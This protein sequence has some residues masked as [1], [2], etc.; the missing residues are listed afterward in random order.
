[1]RFLKTFLILPLCLLSACAMKNHSFV[2]NEPLQVEKEIMSFDMP[3][4]KVSR[5]FLTDLADDVTHRATGD[6]TVTVRYF[7]KKPLKA[8]QQIA[9]KQGAHV[10]SYLQQQGVRQRILVLS[11]PD[12]EEDTINTINISYPALKAKGPSHCA[13]ITH[14]DA[15]RFDHGYDGGYFYGCTGDRY[16]SEMIA[17]PGDL[18]GNDTTAA[19]DSQRLGKS[20]ETYRAGERATLPEDEGVS[21]SNVYSK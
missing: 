6:I 19:A 14:A 3:S 1:M 21:A 13:D 12:H 20:L 18:L 2:S 8:T 5:A 7:M 15:D 4:N 11:A 16:L 17:R 10:K 9:D